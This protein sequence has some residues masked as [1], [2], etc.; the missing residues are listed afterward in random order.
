MHLY[1]LNSQG[2]QPLNCAHIVLIPKIQEPQEVKDY[3]PISLTHSFAKLFSKLLANRL[4]SKIAD[5][6]SINQSAF[7]K[8]RC[9]QGNFMYV[10]KT[11]QKL[12]KR[13]QH[14]IFIKLDI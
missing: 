9:I 10:Q 6:I 2:L 11:I 13:K 5:I 1:N 12:D 8:K 14:S 3:R 4:S 7:I